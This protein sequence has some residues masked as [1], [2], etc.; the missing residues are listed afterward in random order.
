MERLGDILKTARLEKKLTLEQVEKDTNIRQEFI[1][2]MEKESWDFFSEYV[3]LRS[4]LRTYCRYLELDNREYLYFLIE[5]LKPKPRPQKIPE[6]IDLTTAPCRKTK[7]LFTILAIVVLF[8][9]SYVYKQYLNPVLNVAEVTQIDEKTPELALEFEQKQGIEA[10]QEED[11]QN[12][13]ITMFNLA[14]KCIDDRCWVEVKNGEDEYL[15]R[16]LMVKDEEV[17]F[18]DLQK[19]TLKLGNAGQM[20]VTINDENLGALGEI[21]AVITKTYGVMHNEIIEF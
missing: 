21:G 11:V 8:V 18:N 7:V 20:Q 9:T 4:F 17:S 15:Y 13:E 1:E 6:E 19:V 12:Q 10:E 2:A 16:A 14:L 5:D 3:Y